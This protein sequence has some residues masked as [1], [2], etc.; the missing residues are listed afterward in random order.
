MDHEP[1]D[2]AKW[3]DAVAARYPEYT[4]L[5][6]QHVTAHRDRCQL[7]ARRHRRWFRLTGV[8]TIVFS[9]S[10]P[11]LTAADFSA[12]NALISLLAIGVAGLSGLRAFYQWDQSWKLYRSQEL[13]LDAL[14]TRWQLGMMLIVRS[15]PADADDQAH[16]L[17][18][19]ILN[20]AYESGLTELS[21]FFSAIAWPQKA[22]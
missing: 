3:D 5:I 16:A 22:G 4:Q 7:L 6:G 12:R 21:D 1:A 17:T 15:A 18:L 2:P 8:L 19:G 14:L 20:E 9:V 13:T 10:L 11:A